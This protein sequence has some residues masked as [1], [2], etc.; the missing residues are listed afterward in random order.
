[1]FKSIITILDKLFKFIGIICVLLLLGTTI[2]IVYDVIL[3]Y[4]FNDVSIALQELEWHLFSSMFLVGISYTIIHD[5][6]VRVDFLYEKFNPNTKALINVLGVIFFI[7]P[8][9]VLV[10]WYGIDFSL[11]AL[12]TMEKSGDPGGL[13]HRWAIKA[14]IPLSSALIILASLHMLVTNLNVV[15]NTYAPLK[16]RQYLCFKVEDRN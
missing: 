8:L 1:M 5:E 6:H 14:M 11:D 15:L 16:I 2:N 13:T 7:I 9:A 12:S 10:I 3:R 4:I